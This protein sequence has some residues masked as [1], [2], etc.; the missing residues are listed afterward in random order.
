[1]IVSHNLSLICFLLSF[2]LHADA[3]GSMCKVFMNALPSNNERLIEID[4]F[5]MAG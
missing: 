3:G 1:M 4:K 2:N 5:A